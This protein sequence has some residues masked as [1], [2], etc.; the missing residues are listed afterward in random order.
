VGLVLTGSALVAVAGVGIGPENYGLCVRT[1]AKVVLIHLDSLTLRVLE[2]KLRL[3]SECRV[4]DG[5]AWLLQETQR[6]S[7]IGAIELGTRVVLRLAV[8]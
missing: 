7:L 5:G 8:A 3:R 6:V 4:L 1:V 2:D